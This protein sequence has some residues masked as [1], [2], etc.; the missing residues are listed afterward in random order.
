M[1]GRRRGQGADRRPLAGRRAGDPGRL[2][3]RR[4][5]GRGNGPS[6]ASSA[7]CRRPR[8]RS[9]TARTPA[10]P[11]TT[12]ARPPRPRTSPRSACPTGPCRTR[13]RR[14][15]S[16]GSKGWSLPAVYDV[17]PGST[18]T[19]LWKAVLSKSALHL[20]A[21]GMPSV[22]KDT[23]F[24]PYEVLVMASLIEREAITADFPKVS[25]VTYNRLAQ[26]MKLGYDSTINYVLD[27]PEITTK[28]SDRAKAGPYNTYANFGLPPTPISVAQR[29]GDRR[30][31]EPGDRASGCSSSSARRTARPA[32]RS[33]TRSTSATS[34]RRAP[35]M[36]SERSGGRRRAAV[37]GSPVA[38][39]LSPVLHGAA[40]RALGLDVD[41]RADRVHGR[42]APGL[43]ATA[44]ARSGPG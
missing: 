7:S 43:R 36:S 3:T 39:S 1:S 24:T 20:Q 33:P 16:A 19:E 28:D 31:G 30:G 40:Y 35:T 5:E 37:L 38:H 22:A 6:R 2:A 14:S 10:C 44:S 18:A 25:R 23:G 29:Q 12:C 42:R 13:R 9:S 17:R 11:P 41:L 26:P 27:R 4:R 21:T 34:T 8:A 32:S 15:P